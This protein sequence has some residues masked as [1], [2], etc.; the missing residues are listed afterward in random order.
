MCILNVAL[1]PFFGAVG[2]A[3]ASLVAQS[4]LGVLQ[5]LVVRYKMKHRL[6]ANTWLKLMIMTSLMVLFMF[7]E[8]RFHW[9]ELYYILGIGLLWIVLVFG[10]KII[11]VVQVL[12]MLDNKNKAE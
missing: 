9:N 3:I 6:A 5:Y 11:D 2:A 10:L 1:I 7:L 4:T 8:I 12:K